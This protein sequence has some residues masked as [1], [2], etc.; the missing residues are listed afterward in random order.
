MTMTQGQQADLAIVVKY[1]ETLFEIQWLQAHVKI[2]S[3]W[4]GV[5]HHNLGRSMKNISQLCLA[6]NV[7][8]PNCIKPKAVIKKMYLTFLPRFLQISV[9]GSKMGN[10]PIK[11][12]NS[13]TNEN[14]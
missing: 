1:I 7:P 8:T 11:I 12:Q 9:T 14:N 4:Y 2:P 10:W 6:D 13:L 3:N 5:I